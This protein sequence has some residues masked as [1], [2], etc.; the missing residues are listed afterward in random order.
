MRQV[1]WQ[2]WTEDD[3]KELRRAKTFKD[4]NGIAMRILKK[5]PQ[6]IVQVCGPI[7]SGGLGSVKKNLHR[8]NAVIKALDR[9]GFNIFNQLPF[10]NDLYRLR[11]ELSK[12][13]PQ[14]RVDRELLNDFYLPIFESGLVA[15]FF[16]IP[17]WKTSFG[18]RWEHRQLERLRLTIIYL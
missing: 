2:Y 3:R 12:T 4:L 8:F 7:T 9:E 6:P 16:F 17:D 1:N 10:E 15:S 13:R 14:K 18:A 11:R 5:M